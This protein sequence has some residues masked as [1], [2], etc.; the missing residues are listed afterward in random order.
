MG[1]G[2]MVEGIQEVKANTEVGPFFDPGNLACLVMIAP[3]ILG[4]LSIIL[5]R[6][7]R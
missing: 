1:S 6:N 2:W 3:S 7:M 4:A 5:K